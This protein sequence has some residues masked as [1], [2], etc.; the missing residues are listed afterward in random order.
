MQSRANASPIQRRIHGGHQRVHPRWQRKIRRRF[1]RA[2][3]PRF[4]RDEIKRLRP[5]G[6]FLRHNVRAHDAV[7]RR[8]AFDDPGQIHRTDFLDGFDDFF[9]QRW[10]V[11]RVLF[12]KIK[13]V[14][15]PVFVQAEIQVKARLA[16][17]PGDVR[18]GFGGFRIAIIAVQIDAVGVFALVQREAD[19]IQARHQKNFGVRR[20]VI[21]PQQFQCRERSGGFVTVNAR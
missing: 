9:R 14:R 5:V 8:T 15:F 19:G 13:A 16:F 7:F 17:Q 4:L 6:P 12:V 11:V 1:E 18:A 2:A 3:E 20:P 10:L 21:F